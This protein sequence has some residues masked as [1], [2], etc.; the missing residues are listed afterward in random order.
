MSS[1]RQRARRLAQRYGAGL[2]QAARRLRGAALRARRHLRFHTAEHHRPPRRRKSGGI[3]SRARHLPPQG[4]LVQPHR[5]RLGSGGRRRGG[6]RGVEQSQLQ[7]RGRSQHA[8]QHDIARPQIGGQ[9]GQPQ[10]TA[11]TQASQ[12]AILAD[13]LDDQ[14]EDVADGKLP[15]AMP[16]GARLHQLRGNH[17]CSLVYPHARSV[18]LRESKVHVA[19]TGCRGLLRGPYTPDMNR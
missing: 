9:S 11:V 8:Q 13:V 2:G 15:Q 1:A 6:R 16:V 4:G 19:A 12:H 3:L 5:R 18:I 14:F 10:Q 17:G 7:L